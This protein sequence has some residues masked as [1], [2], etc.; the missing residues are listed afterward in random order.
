MLWESTWGKMLKNP[1]NREPRSFWGKKWTTRF[2]VPVFEN[3]VE[4][5]ERD[6]VFEIKRILVISILAAF[7][8]LV[9]LRMLGKNHDCDTVCEISLICEST[10]H[11]RFQ[12]FVLNFVR[13]YFHEL[14]NILQ[15]VELRAV[16]E[17]Y[18][19]MGFSWTI[20]GS[21][22]RKVVRLVA[23]RPILAGE[24]IMVHQIVA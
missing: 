1:E 19:I 20:T 23:T 16:M 7:R 13:N 24:E 6:N 14:V 17:V 5:C 9:A 15:G 12:K 10:C 8:V 22:D 3:I 18:K 2:R 11:S 4:M 21:R